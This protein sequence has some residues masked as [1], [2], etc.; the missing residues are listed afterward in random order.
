MDSVNERKEKKTIK[1]RGEGGARE[2][3]KRN[4]SKV[5]SKY[6]IRKSEK[7]E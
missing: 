6:Y 4:I 7:N 3:R 5:R 2:R 1:G